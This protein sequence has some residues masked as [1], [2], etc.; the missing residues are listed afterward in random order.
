MFKLERRLLYGAVLILVLAGLL[1]GCASRESVQPVIIKITAVYPLVGKD[2]ADE[3][4]GFCFPDKG[5]CQGL[6]DFFARY[7]KAVDAYESNG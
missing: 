1:S 4:E 2:V 6:E 5:Q 7:E 3:L